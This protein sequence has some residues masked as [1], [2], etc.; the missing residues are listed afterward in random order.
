MTIKAK[1]S[2]LVTAVKTATM[3]TNRKSPMSIILGNVHL[4]AVDGCLTVR[5]TNITTDVSV[6]LLC[7][8]EINTTVDGKA[9][10]SAIATCF[11]RAK[12]RPKKGDDSIVS[13][14]Q[15]DNG[16]LIVEGVARLSLATMP[17]ADYPAV[18]GCD[19][20]NPVD[21]PVDLF[22]SAL[23]FVERAISED[24]TR[25]HLNGVCFHGDKLVA[26]DGHRLHLQHG[27][28]FVDEKMHILPGNGAAVLR[29]VIDT[30]GNGAI[31]GGFS[32]DYATFTVGMATVTVKLT[33]AMF[34][35]Y[36]QVIPSSSSE[37]SMTVD[38]ES[39]MGAVNVGLKMS[40]ERSGEIR[41]T[42][43]DNGSMY[44]EV[45]NPDTGRSTCPFTGS[46]R[47]NIPFQIGVNGRY[48]AEFLD[49]MVEPT[50]SLEMNSALDPI[51]VTSGN[52]TTVVMPMRI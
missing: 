17:A 4:K 36:D 24:I 1:Q 3:A 33:D 52:R 22:S 28:P 18:V 44:V 31:T 39:F 5:G 8:G 10:V 9:L 30:Y 16:F 42:R 37:S 45:N 6:F 35:P 41:I 26:T 20:D 7:D 34:P 40:P 21:Y 51:K 15:G 12:G 38:R 50:I 32:G 48:L 43:D 29:R 2:D 47:E 46:P 14:S 25:Y 11:P 49:L 27:L 13:L 23:E 19:L